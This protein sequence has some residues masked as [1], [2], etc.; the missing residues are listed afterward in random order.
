MSHIRQCETIKIEIHHLFFLFFWLIL[1]LLSM[2]PVWWRSFY[3]FTLFDIT[4]HDMMWRKCSTIIVF[5]LFLY[6]RC[7]WGCSRI[8][9]KGTGAGSII[10]WGCLISTHGRYLVFQTI[11]AY[12]KEEC[13]IDDL[14]LKR[15]FTLCSAAVMR[16]LRA[17]EAN[18][19][20]IIS[21]RMK[22]LLKVYLSVYFSVFWIYHSWL[23]CRWLHWPEHI[24]FS[25]I[26]KGRNFYQSLWLTFFQIPETTRHN[27]SVKHLLWFW[28]PL[29]R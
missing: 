16:S 5:F 13:V 17:A 21:L 29:F 25:I 19:A 18:T 22:R 20:L 8:L 23:Q 15:C 9:L 3:I 24:P 11:N 10:I 2:H 27:S 1:C 7:R 26:E 6:N 12:D 14:T 28:H 4:C